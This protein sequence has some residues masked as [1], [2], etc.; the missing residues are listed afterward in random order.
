MVPRSQMRMKKKVMDE[1]ID[2]IGPIL[3]V[4][5]PGKSISKKTHIFIELE[6]IECSLNQ[7]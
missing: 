7:N 5:K 2:T 1:T 4:Y 3:Q 6:Q